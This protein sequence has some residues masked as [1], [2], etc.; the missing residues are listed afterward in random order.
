MV[1]KV[2]E[3]KVIEPS[4]AQDHTTPPTAVTLKKVRFDQIAMVIP[5]RSVDKAESEAGI[6]ERAYPMAAASKMVE[7]TQSASKE[8]GPVKTS[9]KKAESDANVKTSEPKQ[10]K[11]VQPK[12][13]R[14]VLFKQSPLVEVGEIKE[15]IAAKKVSPSK[16]APTH[17]DFADVEVTKD[18]KGKKVIANKAKT[19][20]ATTQTI[21]RETAAP[22]KTKSGDVEGR[23]DFKA[24]EVFAKKPNASELRSIKKV[25]VERAK[26]AENAMDKNTTAKIVSDK[27]ETTADTTPTLVSLMPEGADNFRK[28]GQQT[29]PPLPQHPQQ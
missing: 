17:A 26:A 5:T 27:N 28:Q 20:R 11:T 19:K 23:K 9:P 10:E 14:M 7:P 3:K 24:K 16:A 12:S 1:E 15:K 13:P 18:P 29:L 4:H 6:F 8:A 25:Q 2:V 21:E 22:K